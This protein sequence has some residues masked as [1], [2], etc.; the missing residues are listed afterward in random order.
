M[1]RPKRTVVDILAALATTERV[2][3]FLAG[4]AERDEAIERLL[5]DIAI[6]RVRLVAEL[7]GLLVPRTRAAFWR[8]IQTQ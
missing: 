5:D 2:S 8:S 4:Y 3:A 7:R 1:G 6:C